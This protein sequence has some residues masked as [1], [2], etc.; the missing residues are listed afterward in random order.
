MMSKRKRIFRRDQYGHR[1]DVT[2]LVLFPGDDR[3]PM[4][5]ELEIEDILDAEW[6]EFTSSKGGSTLCIRFRDAHLSEDDPAD[7]GFNLRTDKMTIVDRALHR[8]H[9]RDGFYRA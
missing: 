5:N 7:V 1:H 9:R 3:M 8:C 6:F 2:N 4:L